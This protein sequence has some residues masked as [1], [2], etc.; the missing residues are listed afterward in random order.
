[1]RG[2]WPLLSGRISPVIWKRV[3]YT[4]PPQQRQYVCM[5]SYC[6][7]PGVT[8]SAPLNSNDWQSHDVPGMP[9]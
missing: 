8:C 7:V 9:V 6:F 2:K 5:T 3:I 4:C 1:M